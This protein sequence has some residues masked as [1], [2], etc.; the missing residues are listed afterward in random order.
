[1]K[2]EEARTVFLHYFLAFIC[3]AVI[4]DLKEFL[5]VAAGAFALLGILEVVVLIADKRLEKLKSD[6]E[7]KYL[8]DD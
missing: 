3:L 6:Y 4:M 8:G 5:V 7:K 2:R 1:M